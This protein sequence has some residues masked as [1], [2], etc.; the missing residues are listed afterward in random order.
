LSIDPLEEVKGKIDHDSALIYAGNW[1]ETFQ[2]KKLKK[3]NK[4]GTVF[5]PF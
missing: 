1:R 4:L 2:I 5:T 3:R